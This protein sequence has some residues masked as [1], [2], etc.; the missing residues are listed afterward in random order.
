MYKSITIL[1]ALIATACS[2]P[3]APSKTIN[4]IEHAEQTTVVLSV[5]VLEQGTER[6]IFAAAV[7]GGKVDCATTN[8]NGEVKF[9]LVVDNRPVRVTVSS[10]GYTFPIPTLQDTLTTSGMWIFHGVRN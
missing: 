8:M 2:N 4:L 1:I 6:P 3:S 9:T 5:R 7:C 10:A